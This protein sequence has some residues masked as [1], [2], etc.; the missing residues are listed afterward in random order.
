MTNFVT[1]DGTNR[2]V[3]FG[4]DAGSAKTVIVDTATGSRTQTLQDRTGVIALVD[5]IT[6][7]GAFSGSLSS[8]MTSDPTITD[9]GNGTITVGTVQCNLFPLSGGGTGLMAYTVTGGT[10]SPTNGITSYIV[11]NYNGG[12]PQMQLIT[13]VELITETDVIPVVT[14]FRDSNTI[15]FFGWDRLGS[16]LSNKLH[17]SIVKT[18][19]YRHETGLALGETG[20]RIVTVTSGRIWTGAVKRNVNAFNSST[21][22]MYIATATGGVWSFTPSTQY[23]NTRYC[24]GT[25]TF[26]LTNN[27][28]AVNFVYKAIDDAL[29][30]DAYIILGQG[31]YALPDALNAQP[32][33]SIPALI[34]S[35]C[36]LVGR[37][38]VLK[39]ASS[40]TSIG[41]AF[42]T[43]FTA[44]AATNHNDLSNIQGGTA[45]QYF[46]LTQT[47]HTNLTT[48]TSVTG[49]RASGAALQN[50]LTVLASKG[51]IT[52]NTSA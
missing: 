14:L 22:T 49:S 27:R 21:D 28:Y 17:Q 36:I 37:I 8:G 33:G 48:A 31:D 11:V 51:I 39:S 41:S 13:N 52:D 43:N 1:I 38:I 40:A 29:H 25:N 42:V 16:A 12:T 32:P 5:D 7:G 26:T 19:R 10:F 46:H 50:L 18:T 45:A 9:N 24:D 44:S 47:Q 30:T 15:H 6:G 35:H 34:S 23:D 20:T 4:D 3:I 2:A